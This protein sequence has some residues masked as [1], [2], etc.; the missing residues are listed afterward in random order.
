M[1]S[2]STLN[3]AERACTQL[4]HYGQH[5]TFTAVAAR[6]GPS[7]TTLYRNPAL[8]AVIDS[9]RTAAGGTLAGLTDEIST[10]HTAIDALAAKVRHHEE[11]ADLRLIPA[12]DGNPAM[13]P[14]PPA[15]RPGYWTSSASISADPDGSPSEI[16]CAKNRPRRRRWPALSCHRR[17]SHAR[18]W[19]DDG[20]HV[21]KPVV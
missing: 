2:T 7:R 21:T 16:P 5:V 1:T 19:R 10:L 18:R 3:R 20:L 13:I 15:S 12:H 9:H 8:R 14:N 6:T 17:S 11:H 4:R